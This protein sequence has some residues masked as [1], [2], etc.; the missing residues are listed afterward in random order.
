MLCRLA[1]VGLSLLLL[2]LPALGQTEG[3]ATEPTTLPS[4]PLDQTTPRGTLKLYFTA[5]A[6]S[7]G[8]AIASLL[9]AGDFAEE[10]MIAALAAA[11]NCDRQLTEAMMKRFPDQWK[12]DPRAQANKEL[13]GV[14]QAI[15]RADE[16]IS[17]DIA[18]IQAAG[19]KSPLTLRRVGQKWFIPLGSIIGS[20]GPE[21]LEQRAHQIMIQVQV[22]RGAITDVN[23][24][25]FA[26]QDAA[27]ADIKQR[28]ITTALADHQAHAA[29]QPTT[30]PQ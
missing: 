26:T 12:V 4:A 17:G 25:K 24:G 29:T 21:A 7:D 14:Y 19:A 18:T 6:N 5:G 30:Q 8:D 16:R 27:V 28:M 11:R 2:T 9:L 20:P 23:A 15:D 22:M 10:H 13:P 3:P 1:I